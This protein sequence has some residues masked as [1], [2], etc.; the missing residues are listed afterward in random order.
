MK[1]MLGYQYMVPDQG[2]DQNTVAGISG[3]AKLGDK[4]GEEVAL[5]SALSSRAYIDIVEYLS[6]RY[7]LWWPTIRAASSRVAKEPRRTVLP[8]CVTLAW[9]GWVLHMRTMLTPL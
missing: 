1:L 9:Y 6:H 3:T 7:F 8:S 4:T 5:D 2:L